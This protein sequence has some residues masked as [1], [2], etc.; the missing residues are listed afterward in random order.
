M[1]PTIRTRD[2]MEMRED[3]LSAFV[4]DALNERER[5]EV[6]ERLCRDPQW[7]RRYEHYLLI[8]AAL[9]GDK[10]LLAPGVLSVAVT[11][12]L[13][14]AQDGRTAKA[15]KLETI[16][17][18][19]RAKSPSLPTRLAHG[20]W[21]SMGAR[22][23]PGRGLAVTAA[24]LILAGAGY[25]GFPQNDHGTADSE[26]PRGSM[27]EARPGVQGFR[28]AFARFSGGES[29]PLL[30]VPDTAADASGVQ[31]TASLDSEYLVLGDEGNALEWRTLLDS[32]TVLTGYAVAME[33]APQQRTADDASSVEAM[34]SWS[35]SRGEAAPRITQIG[36][37]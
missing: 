29:H 24:L 17:H 2:G 20:V 14:A 10:P 9:R 23:H 36:D 32:N 26:L 11:K 15:G 18:R 33:P 37:R 22:H 21:R 1:K 30:V 27:A 19:L 25:F 6:I 5:C 4:D 13:L 16:P 8:G 35:N 12:A 31:R 34:S 28:P 7:R 3:L